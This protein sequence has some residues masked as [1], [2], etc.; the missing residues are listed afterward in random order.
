MPM[1]FRLCAL[2]LLMFVGFAQPALSEDAW[3]VALEQQL[4][5]AE[6]CRLNYLTDVSI[7]KM[8]DGDAIT[9]KAHCEDTRSFDVHLQPGKAK[10]EISAC[11]PT[12]C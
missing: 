2:V 8:A 10:F 11:K 3:K 1:V 9:A 7:S 12:Y 5:T 6:K 4:L